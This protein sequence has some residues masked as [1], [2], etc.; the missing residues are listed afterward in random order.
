MAIEYTWSFPE[1]KVAP[2]EDGLTDVVKEVVY[3]YTATEGKYSAK[4]MGRVNLVAPDPSKFTP[5]DKITKDLAISWVEANEDMV[6][7]RANLVR[8]INRFKSEPVSKKVPF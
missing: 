6:A 8:E 3:L 7:I 1:F 2:S 5:Y 4:Y